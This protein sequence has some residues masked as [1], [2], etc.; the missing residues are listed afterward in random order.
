MRH[1]KEKKGDRKIEMLEGEAIIEL[2]VLELKAQAL[3]EVNSRGVVFS[4]MQVDSVKLVFVIHG[5]RHCAYC[6]FL[7]GSNKSETRA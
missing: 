3:I 1:N 7:R 2:T 5:D 6:C 4:D